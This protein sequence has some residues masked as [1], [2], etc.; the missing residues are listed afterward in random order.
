M[1]TR[2]TAVQTDRPHVF[3]LTGVYDF[4]WGTTVGANWFV[5]SGIP[6]ST[7]FRSAATLCSRKAGTTSAEHPWC[8]SWT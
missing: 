4:K 7:A 3:K 8:L 1:A 2:S 5:E 6:Q